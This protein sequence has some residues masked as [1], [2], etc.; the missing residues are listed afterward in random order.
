M[1]LDFIDMA[2]DERLKLSTHIAEHDVYE[3]GH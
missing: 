2:P 1:E 3:S